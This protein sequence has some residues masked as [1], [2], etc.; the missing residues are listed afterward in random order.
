MIQD[1]VERPSDDREVPMLI[2]ELANLGEKNKERPLCYPYSVKARAIIHGHLTRIRLP[3]DTLEA[4]RQL[5][6]KKTPFLIQEMIQVPTH[7]LSS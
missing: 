1:V 3:P 5:I 2:K 6:L 7:R 4:D